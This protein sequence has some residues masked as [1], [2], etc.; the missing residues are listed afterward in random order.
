MYMGAAAYW[1]L[2]RFGTPKA[3]EVRSAEHVGE[4][5]EMSPTTA[6]NCD[7]VEESSE[8]AG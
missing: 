8:V 3:S 1:A 4:I 7:L 2:S 6:A 5:G